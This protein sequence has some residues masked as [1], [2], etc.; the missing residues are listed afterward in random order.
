MNYHKDLSAHHA[1][2]SPSLFV[3][4]WVFPG[5]GQWIIKH[6]D[7]SLEVDAMRPKIRPVLGRVPNPTQ[8]PLLLAILH[9]CSYI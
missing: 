5:S 9:N 2:G 4:I 3:W 6:I 8:A 7:R 1:D